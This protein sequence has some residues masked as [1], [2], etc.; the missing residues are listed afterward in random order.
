MTK[1]GY[2]DSY[3]LYIYGAANQLHSAMR[4][5][6][7]A[8]ARARRRNLAEPARRHEQHQPRYRPHRGLDQ[9]ATILTER[10]IT[11]REFAAAMG[12]QFCGS[13]YGSTPQS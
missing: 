4:S 8:L 1:A 6:S 11:H 12:T 3:H 2:R 9:S 10:K 7:T 13:T 5:A